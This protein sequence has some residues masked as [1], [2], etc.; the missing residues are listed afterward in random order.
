MITLLDCIE[1]IPQC[2][3]EIRSSYPKRERELSAYFSSRGIGR[4]KRLV[5][6]ASGSSYNSAHG[7]KLFIEKQ[8]GVSVGLQYP[9]MFVNYEGE[10]ELAEEDTVY[11]VIS[12]GG[13]TR[14]VYEALKKLKMAGA[15]CIAVTA[16]EDTPIAREA[17]CFQFMGCGREE[18]M[19]RTI[20]FSTSVAVCCF[21]GL[22]AGVY[23]KTVTE[24]EKEDYLK[25]FD[26]MIQNLSAVEKLSLIHIYTGHAIKSRNLKWIGHAGTE[27]PIRIFN[28]L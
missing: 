2:M 9:N 11:V 25:D 27:E 17:E 28:S 6:I 13:E 19:Y 21:V 3:R 12:Q 18:F 10:F 8:C 4:V 20:G 15:A 1:R 16:Q 7:A 14:L 23:N 24:Q 26:S 5:F 22:A